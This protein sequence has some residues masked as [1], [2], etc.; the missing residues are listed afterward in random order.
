LSRHIERKLSA[1]EFHE[2]GRC[3]RVTISHG[4]YILHSCGEWGPGLLGAVT[5]AQASAA[6]T[7]KFDF[8]PTPATNFRPHS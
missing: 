1:W 2:C 5:V 6:R 8:I 3:G 7:N 4:A